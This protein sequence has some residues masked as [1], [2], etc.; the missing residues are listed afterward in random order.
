MNW[1]LAKDAITLTLA[2]T[3]TVLGVINTVTASKQRKVTLSAVAKFSTTVYSSGQVSPRMGCIVVTNLSHFPV[4]VA[5][6]GFEIIG[7]TCRYAIT[8][9]LTN[10]GL[11]FARK[12]DSRQSLSG[13]FELSFQHGGVP[14]RCYVETE[15]GEKFFGNMLSD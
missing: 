11:P 7:K 1:S 3:G 6:I 10:D 5:E 13:R 14:G 4:Y 12:L 9:P 2:S 15:S 8:Q